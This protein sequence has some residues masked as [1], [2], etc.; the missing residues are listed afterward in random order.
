M[1]VSSVEILYQQQLGIYKNMKKII[2]P[3][4]DVCIKFTE[5]ELEKL[6]LQSGD[7]LSWRI[8]D[9]GVLLE[10]YTTVDIDLSE[11]SREHL[12]YLIK[13]SCDQDISV[14]DVINNMFENYISNENLS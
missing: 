11:W 1:F 5:E 2:E 9:E 13:L 3:T 4:G 10:K 6:S 7:K 12:E 14:N 8:T